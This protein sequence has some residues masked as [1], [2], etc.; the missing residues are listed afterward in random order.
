LI[1][2][3]RLKSTLATQRFL[4]IAGLFTRN[5]K[6]CN[7]L[8]PIIPA[9]SKSVLITP[10]HITIAVIFI[11]N[12]EIWLPFWLTNRAIKINPSYA[13][14]FNNRG[15]IYYQQGN[16]NRSVS[17]YSRSIEI[18]NNYMPAYFNRMISYYAAKEYA[19][20][21][22][23][24]DKVRRFGYTVDPGMLAGLTEISGIDK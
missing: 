5:K 21:R 8:Y 4:I 22:A 16:F 6:I 18:N 14:A 17:D 2:T 13:Q 3:R 24:L 23:D 11:G 20:A 12:R 7:K 15:L 19:L 9:P 1:T 10:I